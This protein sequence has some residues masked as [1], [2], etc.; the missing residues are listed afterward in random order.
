MLAADR[1][2][3]ATI[4]G[5]IEEEMLQQIKYVMSFSALLSVALQCCKVRLQA[6]NYAL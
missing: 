6:T 1:Q 2:L 4:R 3:L 5:M